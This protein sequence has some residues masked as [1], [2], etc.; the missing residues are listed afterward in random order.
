M[1]KIKKMLA[2]AAAAVALTTATAI[3]A[4]ATTGGDVYVRMS[5]SPAGVYLSTCNPANCGYYYM[6]PG[7][8]EY[9]NVQCFKFFS[10]VRGVSQYGYSYSGGKWW[11]MSGNNVLLVFT[12]Y[13]T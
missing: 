2:T 9:M 10:N 6:A 13:Y 1:N 8:T 3:P 11:C 4:Q 7:E 5:G 12:T